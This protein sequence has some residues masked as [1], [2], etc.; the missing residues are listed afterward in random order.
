MMGPAT[1]GPGGL[2]TLDSTGEKPSSGARHEREGPMQREWRD[3]RDAATWLVTLT[4]S[5]S[6]VEAEPAEAVR[7]PTISFHRPGRRPYWTPY[8]LTKSIRD[9]SD[10]ELM[11]LL[12]AARREHASREWSAWS[13]VRGGS[14]GQPRF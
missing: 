4:T 1:P 5:D 11:D 9:A 10:Q 12:D 6:A 3:P 8:G 14:Q 13:R 7:H 2:D